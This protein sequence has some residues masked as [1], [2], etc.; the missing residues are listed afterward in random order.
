M[1]N[2]Y[3][4]EILFFVR[5]NTTETHP[6]NA[7]RN[8]KKNKNYIFAGIFN[9]D[10]TKIKN[11]LTNEIFSC[12]SNDY[13]FSWYLVHLNEQYIPYTITELREFWLKNNTYNLNNSCD[14]HRCLDVGCIIDCYFSPDS[15]LISEKDLK[16][17]LNQI[18]NDIHDTY[19][20]LIKQGKEDLKNSQQKDNSYLSKNEREF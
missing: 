16:K 8:I 19:E 14:L 3:Q 17:F 20:Q 11:I 4:D 7:H 13:L 18:N 15:E 12:K 1:K 9:K 2:Y 10:K 5:N 6:I